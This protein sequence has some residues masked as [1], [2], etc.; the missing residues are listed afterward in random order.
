MSLVTPGM[1]QL[2][3]ISHTLTYI[4]DFHKTLH[5]IVI[6]TLVLINLIRITITGYKGTIE[7]S[8]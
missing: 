2:E 3:R 7:C 6:I 1:S 4:T 8:V 5:S